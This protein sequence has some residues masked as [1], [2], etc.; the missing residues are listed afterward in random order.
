VVV[1]ES[2]P[3]VFAPDVLWLALTA[4]LGLFLGLEQE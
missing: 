4:A 3:A 2:T 1:T